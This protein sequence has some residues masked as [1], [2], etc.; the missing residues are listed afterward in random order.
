MRRTLHISLPHPLKDW[1]DLEVQQ[2]GY[3]SPNT[4]LRHLILQERNR[5]GERRRTRQPTDQDD[6]LLPL[7]GL[8][9]TGRPRS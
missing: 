8:Y 4:F 3:A 2:R 7:R 6:L 5:V 1:L 9:P